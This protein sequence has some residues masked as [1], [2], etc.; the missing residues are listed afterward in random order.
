MARF[1]KIDSPCPYRAR[2]S[3]VMDGDHCR[4]CDRNVYDLSGWNDAE[5]T[6][7]LAGCAQEVCVSYRLPLR[8]A[9]AALA[10]AAVATPVAAQ[11]GGGGDAMEMLIVVGGI[12]DP[13]SAETI[14]VPEGA[15]EADLPEIPVVYEDEAT[16]AQPSR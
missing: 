15:E 3:E 11:S 4:M 10:A 8:V 9:A 16:T 5:R 13:R 2:L 14:E 1:P 12:S 6:A 7:F